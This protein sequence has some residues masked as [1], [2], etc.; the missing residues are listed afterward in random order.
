MKQVLLRTDIKFFLRGGIDA[1]VRTIFLM[2]TF[3]FKG[4][5]FDTLCIILIF[6]PF[7]FKKFIFSK[8]FKIFTVVFLI[9]TVFLE[10]VFQYT[11]FYNKIVIFLSEEHNVNPFIYNV[12]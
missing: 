8:I 12:H 9:E 4:Y 3:P 7:L 6:N 11:D 5:F 1:I 10:V 2:T